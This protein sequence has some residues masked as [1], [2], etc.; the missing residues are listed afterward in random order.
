MRR[1]CS[2]RARIAHRVVVRLRPVP[3]T[4]D[5]SRDVRARASL[6]DECRAPYARGSR[7]SEL[8]RV[9]RALGH[10]TADDVVPR[11]ARTKQHLREFAYGAVPPTPR[12][13][14]ASNRSHFG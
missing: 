5:E 14:Q 12:E 4:R 11:A 9:A 8:P 10:V 3:R 2:P 13:L 7:A 1:E 6:P